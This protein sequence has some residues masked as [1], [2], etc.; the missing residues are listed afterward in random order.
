MSL[1]ALSLLSINFTTSS[2]SGSGSGEGVSES[3]T[4]SGSTSTTTPSPYLETASNAILTGVQPLNDE[5]SRQLLEGLKTGGIGAQIPIISKMMEAS[6]RANSA[7]T[8]QLGDE[9][10]RTGLA[11][12][13]FGTTQV[14]NQRRE[15]EYKTSQIGPNFVAELLKLIPGFVGEAQKTGVGGLSQASTTRAESTL[16]SDAASWQTSQQS[17]KSSST[18]GGIL[19]G[20][21]FIFLAAEGY[22]HPAVRT[23]RDRHMTVRN[24]R[25]YYWLS[26]RLVPAM[27]TR[28]WLQRLVRLTLTQPCAAYARYVYGVKRWGVLA[29]PLA[30]AWR[31]VFRLCS[32]QQPYPRRGTKEVI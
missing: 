28:R 21:C 17:Q 12:T 32:P 9:L 31:A 30:C 29:A 2:G 5:F 23:Y 1:L 6:R 3:T 11:G 8:S 18:G 14:A 4:R 22:L 25:G 15:G 13:P 16:A 26:D 24:V 19:S 20:C 7:S 10:A 27:R